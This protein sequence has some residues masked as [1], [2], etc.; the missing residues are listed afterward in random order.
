MFARNAA[1]CEAVGLPYGVYWF[2]Y[3]WSEESARAEAGSCLQL[4]RGRN[5]EYPV[6]FDFEG[7]S[8]DYA[9]KNGVVVTKPLVSALARAFCGRVSAAKYSPMVYTNPSYLSSY[10]DAAI[11]ADYDIWLAQWPAT[12]DLAAK[13]AQ[14]GG[15]WQ[16][17]SS[18]SVSG[19][20]GRV[21][22]DAAY[23]DYPAL[24]AASGLNRPGG[25]EAPGPEPAKS[26]NELARD[27]VMAADISD[28]ENPDAPATRQQ[29]WTMLYR[30][31]GGK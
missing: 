25:Q 18:G 17:T 3:A 30:L 2:S 21:D 31:T 15:I 7:D 5:I 13:P 12:P 4:I 1:G 22:M 8:A 20:S 14:A 23:L 6:A 24:I 19:I 29:V 28:G 11:P 27:W 10:Y 16:Y 26:E 9:A